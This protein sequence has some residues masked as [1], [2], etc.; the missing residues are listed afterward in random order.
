MKTAAVAGTFDTKAAE[1]NYIAQRL[2]ATGVN[3]RTIDLSTGETGCTA[4]DVTAEEIASCHP[5]GRDQLVVVAHH[6]DQLGGSDVVSLKAKG[7]DARLLFFQDENHWVLKPQNSLLWYR[8]VLG[9]LQRYLDR[10]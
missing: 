10:A 4:T 3:V 5:D 8:E 9:W 1:L 6:V 2:I 7:V